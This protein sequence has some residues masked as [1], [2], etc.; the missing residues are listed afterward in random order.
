M[1]DCLHLVGLSD[2]HERPPQNVWNVLHLYM[3]NTDLLPVV[4]LKTSMKAAF[5]GTIK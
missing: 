3:G 5:A 4:L 1:V 2:I